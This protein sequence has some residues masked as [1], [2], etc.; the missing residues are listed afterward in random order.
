M[1]WPAPTPQGR[2]AVE[3]SLEAAMGEVPRIE[4]LSLD[5][6]TDLEAAKA[7][8]KAEPEGRESGQAGGSPLVV[9]HPDAVVRPQDQD[10]FGSYDLYVRGKLDDRIEDEIRGGLR[11]AIVA[12]RVSASGLDRE[13]VGAIT[14]V[15]RVNSV[16]VTAEGERE[17]NEVRQHPPAGRLHDPAPDVGAD[18]RPVPADLHGG[19][20]VEPRGRGA[21]VGRLAHAAD[22]GQD[23]RPDGRRAP[24]PGPLRGARGRRH[25]QLRGART[26]RRQPCCSSCSPSTCWPTSPSPP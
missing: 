4:V 17:T 21:A 6:A 5:P 1:P 23:P 20:E 14:A 24:D 12:A 19:G 18:Q 7:P 8:L 2:A 10:A 11:E 13:L 22:G 26:A 16:T 15:R 25:G 9:V 3:Q